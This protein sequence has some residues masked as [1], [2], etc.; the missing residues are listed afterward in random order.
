MSANFILLLGAGFSRNWGGWLAS[1]V[2]EYLLGHPAVQQHPD[3]IRTLWN[4]RAKGGFEATLERIQA[5]RRSQPKSSTSLMLDDFQ[6]AIIQMFDDMNSGFFSRRHIEATEDP[7]SPLKNFLLRFDAIFTLNQDLLLERHYL[8]DTYQPSHL[9]RHWNTKELPGI[10]GPEALQPTVVDWRN[11]KWR[12]DADAFSVKEGSQPIFKLHGSSQW[13]DPAGSNLL[14]MGGGKEA[15]IASHP[16]L[17]SYFT[18]FQRRLAAPRTRIM[19]IGYGFQDSHINKELLKACEGNA[20]LFI[21]DPLG[22]EVLNRTRNSPIPDWSPLRD[23][24]IGASRR[25]LS[26]TFVPGSAE[27]SKVLRF[28]DG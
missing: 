13:H 10:K 27:L 1:E 17:R 3:L 4:D 6:L 18:E 7:S 14:V 28:F 2:F 24:L 15:A 9:S 5:A 8:A 20:R 19:S 22:V 11:A 25:S 12:V 23:F 21:I 16:I 26:E